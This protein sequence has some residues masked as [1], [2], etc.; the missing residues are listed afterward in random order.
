MR[1]SVK[2]VQR[3]AAETGFRAEVL[4]KVLHLVE[5]LRAIYGHP[6]TKNRVVL[7]GGTALNLFTFELPRLSVDIDLNYIGAASRD[8]MLEERPKVEQAIRAI[9]D[10]TGL[11]IRMAPKKHAGG[12][13][14]LAYDAVGGRSGTLE[15]DINFLIRTPLW[16]PSHIDSHPL[17]DSQVRVLILDEHEIA[18]GKIAALL[19]RNASRDLF[20]T[21]EILRSK[22]LDMKKLRLALVIYGGFNRIDWRTVSVDNVSAEPAEVHNQ[23]LPMLR[24]DLVPERADL[25]DWTTD[26]VTQCRELLSPLLPF[27][28]SEIEFLCRLND[29]GEIAPELL[30][31]D[32]NLRE[33]IHSHPGLQWKVLNVRKH[34][35]L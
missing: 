11:Q 18:A 13:Y 7:K 32:G 6:F 31:D 23:L 8:A 21:R 14:R 27:T 9:C 20:D 5:L 15:L 29:Q 19:A 22:Q 4:E 34:R 28:E 17:G 10:R 24:A 25:D 12:K 1:L 2:E 33:I 30:T 26:L 3:L 35:E 16:P